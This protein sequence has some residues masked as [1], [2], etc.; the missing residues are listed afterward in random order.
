[1]SA[2]NNR[3]KKSLALDLKSPAAREIALKLAKRA[4]ILIE[5][6]RPGAMPPARARLRCPRARQPAATLSV[7]QRLR[8]G[9]ALCQ[10]ALHQLGGAGLFRAMVALNRGEDGTPH[11]IGA[12]I[13]DT[14][15]GLYA[16]QALG[17]ALY[18]RERRGTG[19]RIAVSLAECG[20]AIL[21]QRSPSISSKTAALACSNVPDRG[22]Y[23]TPGRLGDDRAGHG[24]AVRPPC[25]RARPSRF[26]RR[27]RASPTSPRAPSMRA[28]LVRGLAA[29]CSRAE[30]TAACLEKLRAADILADRINGFDDW[31]ADPHI[32]AT[33]GAVDASRRPTCRQF[34]VPRTPG[35]SADA[36]AALTPAPRYRRTWPRDPRRARLRRR[37]A[38]PTRRRRRAALRSAMSELR[39]PPAPLRRRA[40]SSRISVGERF[41]IP[42]RTVT[43]AHFAAFQTVSGDNHPIHYDIEYCRERGLP[44]PLAHGF[45]MLCF[46]AAG[47]G[48]FAHVIGDCA[49]RL[50]RA[51]VKFLKPVYPGDTLYPSLTVAALT[52]QRTTGVVTR[53]GHRP[54]PEERTGPHR[55]AEIPAAQAVGIGNRLG[56]ERRSSPGNITGTVRS[57]IPYWRRAPMVNFFRRRIDLAAPYHVC[58]RLRRRTHCR[59]RRPCG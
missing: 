48:A 3:G 24:G 8:P 23:R 41:H 43:E 19:S 17:V 47:A 50:H 46:T 33:G 51:V 18:A 54:Q 55:R 35:I 12:I 2:H 6:N 56:R 38:I 53:R 4:D 13:I 26:R 28:P 9:R 40:S 22:S 49:D 5:N 34:K 45:Q 14:L 1:M 31:L 21:G 25:R 36:D 11:R 52:P 58:Q 37:G 7:G 15:T 39:P 44:A 57:N 10:S 32:V 29:S 27:T 16:A 59:C 30:T 42:S 20:A